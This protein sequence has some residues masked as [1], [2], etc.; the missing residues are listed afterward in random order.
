MPDAAQLVGRCQR[1]WRNMFWLLTTFMLVCLRH[2]ES[3]WWFKNLHKS[4]FWIVRSWE[5]VRSSTLSHYIVRYDPP[6]IQGWQRQV[7]AGLSLRLLPPQK[8]ARR[9]T[10]VCWSKHLCPSKAQWIGS[11]G[12]RAT[13]A[14]PPSSTWPELRAEVVFL[15][16]DKDTDTSCH[17]S[18]GV[19]KLGGDCDRGDR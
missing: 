14:I 5:I 8:K 7:W 12:G 18:A 2:H 3:S 16:E 10:R 15:V 4:V 17:F 19:I 13:C 6:A 1:H 11:I 9:H